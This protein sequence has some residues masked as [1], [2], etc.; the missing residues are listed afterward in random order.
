MKIVEIFYSIEGEGIRAGYPC[1]FIRTYGCSC[2][3]SYCDTPYS[4]EGDNYMEMS[5][6][7]IVS[8]INKY[9]CKRVTLTGGEPLIQPDAL[10]LITLLY[11][12]G[13]DVNIETN[14]SVDIRNFIINKGIEHA[15]KA[16]NEVT[17]TVDYKCPSSGQ[18]DK[19]CSSLFCN[20]KYLNS[21]TSRIVV[22]FV[23]GSKEDLDTM[24]RVFFQY[25]ISPNGPIKNIFVSPIFGKIEPKEIVEYLKDNGLTNIRLQLQ[26]HKF[27]WPIDQR[28]V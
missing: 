1:I 17:F 28:G 27:I 19:M 6:S 20:L 23:V 11:N 26:L 8:E 18:E 22:K 16:S 14:G 7:D 15:H 21:S 10:S 2:R 13:Y 3:C 9:N 5:V 25:L 4:Y 12:L 24:K